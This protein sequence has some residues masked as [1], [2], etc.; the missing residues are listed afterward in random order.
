MSKRN[1][2]ELNRRI[3]HISLPTLFEYGD[4]G[5]LKSEKKLLLKSAINP[6]NENRKIS[7]LPS[8]T[9]NSNSSDISGKEKGKL[10]NTGNENASQTGLDEESCVSIGDDESDVFVDSDEG[11]KYIA[12]Q[13]WKSRPGEKHKSNESSFKINGV[14]KLNLWDLDAKDQDF[15]KQKENTDKMKSVCQ[16]IKQQSY[17][18]CVP[19]VNCFEEI[20]EKTTLRIPMIRGDPVTTKE[21]ADS[22]RLW[23]MRAREKNSLNSNRMDYGVM[24][25]MESG[26]KCMQVGSELSV[27]LSNSWQRKNNVV[28]PRH[29]CDAAEAK[30]DMAQRTNA[31][32]AKPNEIRFQTPTPP[33]CGTPFPKKNASYIRRSSLSS[34]YPSQKDTGTNLHGKHEESSVPTR[35]ATAFSWPGSNQGVRRRLSE[36]SLHNRTSTPMPPTDMVRSRST[37]L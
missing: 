8:L 3:R 16:W 26:S 28:T 7:K 15:I 10:V 30:L 32:A 2:E 4:F 19:K 1:S 23:S 33:R 37:E 35:A 24:R 29:N 11:S 36:K 34:S 27:R 20:R 18:N 17:V 21:R 9:E 22:E 12:D 14:R 31:F 13:G 5:D 6:V 25:N